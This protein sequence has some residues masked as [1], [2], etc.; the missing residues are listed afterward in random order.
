METSF[1]RVLIKVRNSM[2][3]VYLD[4]DGSKAV[5]S[6]NQ[7]RWVDAFARIIFEY[8]LPVTCFGEHLYNQGRQ[9]TGYKL[10]DD[11]KI[12]LRFL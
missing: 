1:Y 8:N 11:G 6:V 2:C 5:K 7:K 12:L 10:K 3:N 4:D 9:E